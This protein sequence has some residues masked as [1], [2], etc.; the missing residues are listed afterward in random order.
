MIDYEN[1]ERLF[2]EPNGGL[3]ENSLMQA[4]VWVGTPTLTDYSYMMNMQAQILENHLT[5]NTGDLIEGDP[6]Y[7]K[8]E[9]V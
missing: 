6:S 8:K 4:D 5:N 1:D 2:D 3:E 9:G 7:F